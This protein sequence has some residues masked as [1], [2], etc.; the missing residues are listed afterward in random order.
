MDSQ[1][2]G[3]SV[4]L[5]AVEWGAVGMDEAGEAGRRAESG[6]IKW[7]FCIDE[8]VSTDL[9]RSCHVEDGLWRNSLLTARWQRR[10]GREEEREL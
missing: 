10:R 3:A 8:A 1:R 2:G 7:L 6:G 4:E 9:F 5:L